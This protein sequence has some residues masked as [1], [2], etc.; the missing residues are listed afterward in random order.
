LSENLGKTLLIFINKT[1]TSKRLKS[2]DFTSMIS[3]VLRDASYKVTS[4]F[5]DSYAYFSL[6]SAHIFH[7]LIS[8]NVIFL[9]P[10]L[11]FLSFYSL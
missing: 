7:I 5:S 9:L 3:A 8:V 6:Y 4:H 1:T 10:K 2:G 11:E